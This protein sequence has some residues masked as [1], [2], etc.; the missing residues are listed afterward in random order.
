M[1]NAKATT[2]GCLCGAVRYQLTAEPLKMAICHCTHCQRQSGSAF[3]VNLVVKKDSFVQQGYAKTYQDVGSSGQPVY[4][5]FCESCGS[6]IFSEL[7]MA[8]GVLF[9][10][11]GTLD[12]PFESTPALE[13]YAKHAAIW[14]T[15]VNGAKRFAGAAL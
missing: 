8:P 3:S 13:V 2:G 15:P 1:T 14:L 7:A 11:A 5:H 12:A 6:P 4:R 10:K 9:V